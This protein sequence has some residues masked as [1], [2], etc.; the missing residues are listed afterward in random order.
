MTTKIT[1]RIFYS[2]TVLLLAASAC[3]AGEVSAFV[4]HRFGD[5]R[6]PS[7]NISLQ[8][9]SEQ[10]AWLKANDY[11]VLPLG[12]IVHR[13]RTAQALPERCAVL[14]VDDAFRTFLTGAMPLLRRYGYPVT[15]F[16][17]TDAV[18]GE[19]YLSW[20]E[21]R[22]LAR[23]GVEI[24]SHTASH[25][26]LVDRR[27]GE[28]RAAWLSRVRG[29]IL[30]AQEVLKKELGQAPDLFAYPYGEYTPEIVQMVRELGFVGAVGQQSGVIYRGSD[31]FL[32]PRFPMGGPY[33]TLRGFKQKVAMKALSLRVLSPQSP[34]VGREN[35][36][37]L[38]V[39]IDCP[40]ADLSRMRCFVGGRAE[41]AIRADK[42]VPGRYLV[43][44]TRALTGR[45]TKYTLTA[46][47]RDGMSWYWF[48]QL[49]IFPK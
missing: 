30:K 20:A 48:S 19:D 13:L 4:Y 10:L 27:K 15:L 39:Q 31:L 25:A 33:G 36:P 43:R 11:H 5:P 21:L 42:K 18:G 12:D 49:W 17:S 46:P 23:Q 40:G 37:S 32:L 14:T 26:Y 28:T 1:I 38:A 8:A 16:V 22:R 29:D 6:Y 41:A 9:F 34:I 47:A 3:R 35:P 24:G 7:T 2:L 44:A 45:R